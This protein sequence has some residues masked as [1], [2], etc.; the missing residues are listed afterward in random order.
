MHRDTCDC[1]FKAVSCFVAL[2]WSNNLK[3]LRAMWHACFAPLG[4]D[5]MHIV[6]T[7]LQDWQVA[8]KKQDLHL[9]NIEKGLSTLKGIGEAMGETLKTQDV[10]IDTIDTKVSTHSCWHSQCC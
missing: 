8:K 3:A 9:D 4:I 7:G 10:L 2:P 1:S 6:R 5:L